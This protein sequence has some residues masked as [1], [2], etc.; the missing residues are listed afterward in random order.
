[1]YCYKSRA[2]AVHPA[3]IT[4]YRQPKSMAG[5]YRPC[6]TSLMLLGPC[7]RC[8]CEGLLHYEL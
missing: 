2:R 4:Q 1:M 5:T 6:I 3:P 7:G 8:V